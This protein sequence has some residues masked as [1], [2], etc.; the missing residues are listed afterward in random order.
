MRARLA[1][2]AFATAAALAALAAPAS[3]A[4]ADIQAGPLGTNT[5]T[6]GSYS[7]DA[8]TLA[9]LTILSGS[10]NV[11]ADAPGPDEQALFRTN[12]LS[13]GSTGVDGSQYLP[14]GSYSFNCTVHPG[15]VSGLN[16][17]AGSPL[18]RPE[19]KLKVKTRSLAQAVKKAEVKVKVTI[20]G[21][22]GEAAEV[23][24]RLGKRRIG[25][26]SSASRTSTV[27]IA[28]TKKGRSAL[29]RR[30]K[31]KVKAGATIDFGSPAR[32]KRTLK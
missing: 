2:T 14:L 13:G 19:V 28:L 20:S 8:G 4:P 5:F 26:T 21:G 1:P 23:D 3:A 32:A 24:L 25:V 11:T 18:P 10:H 30:N 17:D 12:T 15:M 31:A 29:E 6:Q 22:S 7:H 27:K 9:Q 16:V